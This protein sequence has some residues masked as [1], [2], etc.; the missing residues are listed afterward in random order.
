MYGSRLGHYDPG[1]G[2]VTERDS[3]SGRD[4]H[5]Y[6]IAVLDGV[7]WYNESGKRPDMLVR[8][9]PA[10]EAFQSW[11]IPSGNI[12]AGIVRHMR[13][14]KDGGLLIHQSATNTVLKVTPRPES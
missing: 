2:V 7:V 9:D 10:T 14:T 3:P 13:T 11:P 1:T 8:F 4:S 12:H 6:A 5:P